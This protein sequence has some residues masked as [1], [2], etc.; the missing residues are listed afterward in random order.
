MDAWTIETR[1]IVRARRLVLTLACALA[2]TGAR[3]AAALATGMPQPAGDSSAPSAKT[4]IEQAPEALEGLRERWR[5]AM[6]TLNVPGLAVAVVGPDGILYRETLGVRNVEED[7]PVDGDTMFYIASITKTYVATAIAKLAEDGKLDLDAT[8]QSILPRFD[9]PDG[10]ADEVTVRDLLCHRHGINSSP[11]V[12]LDAYTGEITE[13]RYWRWMS[14]ADVAGEVSYTNVHFTLAGRVIEA[15]TGE[16]WRD[17][18]A[19]HWFEPMGMARTTGYAD[20]MYADA[21]VAFPYLPQG[22]GWVRSGHK[23]DRTMHAAGGLGTSIDDAARWIRLQLANGA[24]GGRRLLAPETVAEI[25]KTQST[26][27]QPADSIGVRRGFGLGWMKGTYRGRT[28]FEHGG[29]Y[30]GA[31]STFSFLPEE[32]I[33]VAVLVNASSSTMGEIVATDVY[34]RLLGLEPDDRLARY[35]AWARETRQAEPAGGGFGGSRSRG[36]GASFDWS[37][38]FENDDWGTVR[39]AQ[40]DGEPRAWLGDLTGVVAPGARGRFEVVD[41]TGAALVTGRVAE[42]DDSGA[43]R[44]VTIE[45]NSRYR[46]RYERRSEE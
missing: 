35:E 1:R 17:H 46:A 2:L 11:I 15:V 21:N 44:A 41:G 12:R 43:I 19:K 32:G 30:R 8:V 23:T 29:G 3:S 4:S 40:V 34:D 26:Y 7:L 14:E 24:P 33:G 6:E 45:F 18:L 10:A 13:D 38:T 5:G 28:Y 37:G 20:P 42:T 36:R 9:L 16:T 25:R 27:A 22:D 39:F 31:S